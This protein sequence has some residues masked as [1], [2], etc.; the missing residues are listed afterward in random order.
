M[1]VR[2]SA[3]SIVGFG[4]VSS[5]NTMGAKIRSTPLSVTNLIVA[6]KSDSSI[7]LSWDSQTSPAN[8]NSDILGYNVFWDA[9]SAASASIELANVTSNSYST[10]SVV[11]GKTYKFKVRSRNFYGYGPF[12]DII[13]TSAISVP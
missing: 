9:G 5:S 11:T 3:G 10:S 7:S 2:A 8:G 12:S 4:T 13:P 1:I 6:S